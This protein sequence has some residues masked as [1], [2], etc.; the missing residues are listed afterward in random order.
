MLACLICCSFARIG[1]G[2]SIGMSCLVGLVVALYLFSRRS[3]RKHCMRYADFVTYLIANGE[4]KLLDIVQKLAPS[5]TITKKDNMYLWNNIPVFVWLKFG[6]ISADSIVAMCNTCKKYNFSKAYV[7][8]SSKDKNALTLSK[9]LCQINLMFYDLKNIYKYAEKSNL[10]PKNQKYKGY[11]KQTFL[12]A[13]STIFDRKNTKRYIFV[14]F[15]LLLLSLLTPL[16]IYYLALSSISLVLGAI[17]LIKNRCNL[18]S[19]S[20]PDNNQNIN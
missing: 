18:P 15:V 3:G 2:I 12:L 13:L 10:L 20:H 5:L 19:K 4:E 9:K 11:Y 14:S 16:W 17:C 7:I 6:N 1:L 8:A